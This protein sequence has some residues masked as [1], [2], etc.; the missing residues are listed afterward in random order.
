MSG[1]TDRHLANRRSGGMIP[2][3][4]CSLA[5]LAAAPLPVAW[6]HWRYSRPIDV[7]A[8]DS[9]RLVTLKLPPDV[10]AHAAPFLPDLRVIDDAG[11]EVPYLL[12]GAETGREFIPP[13]IAKILENSFSPGHYTQIVLELKNYNGFHSSVR[14]ETQQ[15]EFMEWV[16]VEASDDAR[17]W[18]IVQEHA[19]IFRFPREGHSGTN[20]VTYSSNNARYLRLRVLD[21][22]Q[23]FPVNSVA[24]LGT[25]VEKIETEPLPIP[26]SSTKPSAPDR[27]AWSLDLG[28]GNLPLREVRFQVG[29]GEFVREV[30]IES[31][32]N[33]SQWQW[34]GSGEIYRFAQAGREC[35]QLSVP[36]GGNPQRYVRVEVQNGNDR[37]LPGA[38]PTLYIAAQRIAFEQEQGHTYRLLYGDS[39]AH[40]ARYDLSRRISA[41][42]ID[43]ALVVQPG[44]EEVNA[45]WADPRPWTETHKF[46]IWL[47]VALAVL[48]IG[49]TALQS[50]RRSSASADQGG[51]A[52]R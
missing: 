19:P 22:K 8:T 36:I 16:E 41:Q 11:A 6:Q 29:P 30:T 1:K 5:L 4:L 48:L 45:N 52:Q 26:F 34:I 7:L 32:D 20:V 31:S 14:I 2:L 13:Y 23:K 46:V 37:P 25:P 17:L 12:H 18:R 51:N 44:P 40:P 33:G 24:V 35:E 9:T 21:G 47:A 42:Q 38:V 39:R 28:G 3:L 10:Y 49:Y 43:A 27:T 15:S 50:L